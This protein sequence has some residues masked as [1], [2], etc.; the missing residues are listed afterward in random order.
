MAY[1]ELEQMEFF[2]FHGC[3][4]EEKVVG[5]TFLVTFGYEYN[6]QKA[7][8]SD[9]IHDA[10]DYQTI[11]DII[12]SEMNISANLLEHLANRIVDRVLYSF[13]AIELAN[14]KITKLNPSLGGKMKGVSISLAK[15]R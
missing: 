13:P 7:G 4:P 1:I 15:E 2:A 5:N 14:I 8:I 9:N 6:I 12:K 3:I 11:Y 10:I